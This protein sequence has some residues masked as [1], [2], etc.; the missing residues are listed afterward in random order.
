MPPFI[1][2]AVPRFQRLYRSLLTKTPSLPNSMPKPLV[3]FVRTRITRAGVIPSRSFGMSNRTMAS[4][5][6][7]FSASVS[8]TTFMVQKFC[9]STAVSDERTPTSNHPPQ[10]RLTVVNLCFIF[11]APFSFLP[12]PHHLLLITYFIKSKWWG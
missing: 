12:P 5:G 4:I 2:R 1:I 7:A 10:Q 11:P 6:S 9:F 8:A 3:S